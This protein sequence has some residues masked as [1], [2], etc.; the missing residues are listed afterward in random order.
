MDIDL[1]QSFYIFLAAFIGETFGTMFG[2]GSFFIQ[3]A[4][5]TANIP[6]NIAV[7][8]DIT[9]AAFASVAF[10]YFYRKEEKQLSIKQ[11]KQITLFMAP[12]LIIGALTGSYILY[13]LPEHVIKWTVITI[14]F[15]GLI[16]MSVKTFQN[17]KSDYQPKENFIKHWRPAIIIAGLCLG[18][19]D[20]ISAAGSGILVILTLTLIFRCDM[21]TTL[22]IANILSV[23]SLFTAA[24][25]FLYLGLISLQL[26]IIMIPACLIAGFFGAKIVSFVPERTLRIIYLG[27]VFLLM[28]YMLKD[29]LFV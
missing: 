16:Y 6:A 3:P 17:K 20:G 10:L 14:C 13:L 5:I 15:F 4:L 11:F 27:L 18:F 24:L 19:Y 26:Q 7:P 8:N 23:I 2:G 29:M 12:V 28:N 1:F 25:M 9:A 22:V 21:K